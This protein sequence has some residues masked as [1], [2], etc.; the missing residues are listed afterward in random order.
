MLLGKQLSA[1]AVAN[2]TQGLRLFTG[3]FHGGSACGKC[4]LHE[5]P[6][7]LWSCPSIFK[8]ALDIPQEKRRTRGKHYRKGVLH[9]KRQN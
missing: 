3:L 8:K 2:E 7:A 6:S 1:N 9:G 4:R 5:R